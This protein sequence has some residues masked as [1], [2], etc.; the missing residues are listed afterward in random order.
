MEALTPAQKFVFEILMLFLILS[1][2]L[3]YLCANIVVVVSQKSWPVFQEIRKFPS[4]SEEIDGELNTKPTE[5]SLSLKLLPFV[6][7]FLE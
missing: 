3:E 7:P 4:S 1:P 6:I 5:S 2:E